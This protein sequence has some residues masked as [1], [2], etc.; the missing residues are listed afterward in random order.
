MFEVI[1]VIEVIE[2]IE[3]IEVI[4]VIGE[5][6]AGASKSMRTFFSSKP[7]VKPR[8]AMLSAVPRQL[9]WVRMSVVAALS[10]L[11]TAINIRLFFIV[12]SFLL[13]P[14]HRP[15]SSVKARLGAQSR[16]E[17]QG[18]CVKARLGPVRVQSR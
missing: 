11:S 18:L 7:D 10:T 4:E 15:T 17:G 6:L 3:V 13:I 8:G 14:S 5:A 12:W 2:M 16:C 9:T 1:E